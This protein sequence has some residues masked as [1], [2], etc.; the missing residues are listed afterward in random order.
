MLEFPWRNQVRGSWCSWPKQTRLFYDNTTRTEARR[1][2]PAL[3]HLLV[4][5]LHQ[6]TQK[7]LW[8]LAMRI[9]QFLHPGTKL[10]QDLKLW[11]QS[12]SFIGECLYGSRLVSRLMNSV[13]SG[14]PTGLRK[15]K[16]KPSSL[17][18][19]IL[20]FRFYITKGRKTE[21]STEVC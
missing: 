3:L 11:A 7:P 13:G 2:D 20:F 4:R 16:E 15:S 21:K 18:I 5:T 8:E 1:Q 6:S 9:Y 10:G 19:K 14:L 12:A 17:G